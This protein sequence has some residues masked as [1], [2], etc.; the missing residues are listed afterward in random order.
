MTKRGRKSKAQELQIVQYMAELQPDVFAVIKDALQ[1]EKSDR[2]WAAEQMM[3]LYQKG[4]PQIIGGDP[5][6]QTPIPISI[7]Q[8]ATQK[9]K[10]DV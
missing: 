8:G 5:N 6:N 4:V 7:L 2:R 10:I 9:P 1:G 3:K